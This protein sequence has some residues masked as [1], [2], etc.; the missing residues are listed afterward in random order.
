MFEASLRVGVVSE[1]RRLR[2][3]V[4]HRGRTHGTL[5]LESDRFDAAQ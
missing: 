1:M 5:A 3:V 4:F 2:R